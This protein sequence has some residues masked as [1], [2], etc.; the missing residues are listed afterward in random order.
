MVWR[1][2]D[3]PARP[4]RAPRGPPTNHLLPSPQGMGVEEARSAARAIFSLGRATGDAG[5]FHFALTFAEEGFQTPF[6]PAAC[7][8]RPGFA[9]ATEN[10]AQYAAA[11]ASAG[12]GGPAGVTPAL[13]AAMAAGLRGA[14]ACAVKLATATHVPY[15]GID[16]SINPGLE[17]PS[18]A[19]AY[20]GW[21]LWACMSSGG[22]APRAGLPACA[23]SRPP[24]LVLH[25]APAPRCTMPGFL[26]SRHRPP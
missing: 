26:D 6:F 20:G 23:C 8:T 7:A 24:L 3:R 10:S 5:P 25:S 2:D 14:Q 13:R 19:G 4:L 17:G 12:E 22:G 18:L 11:L 15:L 21:G 16:T 9:I 1:P